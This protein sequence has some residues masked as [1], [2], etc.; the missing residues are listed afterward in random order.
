MS[1]LA[2]FLVAVGL[3]DISRK[4]TAYHWLPT[5]MGPAAVIAA[6]VLAGAFCLSSNRVG[7]NSEGGPFG[8]MG[9]VIDPDGEILALTSE[10]APFA[11]VD[12]DLGAA[13]HAKAT[14][15]RYVHW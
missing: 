11:T 5:A 6:A 4:V 12:I 7:P 8:G 1:A 10:D 15:P 2:V 14:Y 13:E 3:A 9:W